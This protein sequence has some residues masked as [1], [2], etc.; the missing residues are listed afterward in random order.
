[1]DTVGKLPA[2]KSLLGQVSWAIFLAALLA[3]LVRQA[4]DEWFAEEI[5]SSDLMVRVFLLA[6][7]FLL[8]FF[9]LSVRR[10]WKWSDEIDFNPDAVQLVLGGLAGLA[11]WVIAWWGM[12]WLDEKILFDLFGRFTPVGFY[13]PQNQ[14]RIWSVLVIGEV[15]VL[16]LAMLPLFWL[17]LQHAME[18]LPVWLGVVIGGLFFGTAGT[19]VF[20]Q[21]LVG[22]MGYSLCGMVAVFAC[23]AAGSV[24]VGMAV[25]GAFMYANHSFLIDL[26]S[27]VGGEPYLGRVWLTY[28]LLAGL[29]LVL[30]LQIVRARA[31]QQGDIPALPAKKTGISAGAW[32]ALLAVLV[33]LVI[34]GV[35]EIDRRNDNPPQRIAISDETN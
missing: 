20:G 5:Q 32:L 22:L 10:D 17:A 9:A 12:S 31:K 2:S 26:L 13:L 6:G 18:S 25:H 15:V 28:V 27:E 8:P 30:L 14:E 3:F 33:L 4:T 19:L 7:S 35:D 21:G 16:P 29:A 11:V 1:M 34:F 23:R 24:W